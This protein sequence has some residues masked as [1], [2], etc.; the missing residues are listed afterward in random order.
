MQTSNGGLP[1]D[2]HADSKRVTQ[3]TNFVPRMVDP[4]S[5]ALSG[6]E[7]DQAKTNSGSVKVD[8]IHS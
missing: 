5:G 4:G 6:T 1:A 7:P 2:G 8:N 3:D